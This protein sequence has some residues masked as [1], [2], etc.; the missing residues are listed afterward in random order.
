MILRLNSAAHTQH[1]LFEDF[2]VFFSSS[3]ALSHILF[4]KQ[5]RKIF[6]SSIITCLNE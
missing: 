3:L 4:N 2:T 6:S 5:K 1:E